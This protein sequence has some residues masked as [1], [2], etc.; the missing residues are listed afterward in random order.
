[1]TA[2]VNCAIH[3]H[4][5]GVHMEHCDTKLFFRRSE[6]AIAEKVQG[7]IDRASWIRRMFE[8]G[9]A[10]RQRFGEEDVFD[11]TLGNPSVEPP[12]AFKQ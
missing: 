8:Q 4:Q 2:T 7:F 5:K 9:A 11:F 12:E 3:I 1:M 6:M 10:L